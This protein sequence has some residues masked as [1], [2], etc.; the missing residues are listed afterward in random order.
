MLPACLLAAYECSE[1]LEVTRYVKTYRVMHRASGTARLCQ[2]LDYRS[3]VGNLREPRFDDIHLWA[4]L[5]HPSLCHIHEVLHENHRHL[6]HVVFDWPSGRLMRDI[7]FQN[8]RRRVRVPDPQLWQVLARLVD[9]L[10]YLHRPVR[11]RVAERRRFI[12]RHVTPDSIYIDDQGLPYLA[13]PPLPFLLGLKMISDRPVEACLYCAPEILMMRRY[14]DCVDMWS[15]GCTLYEY[16]TNTPFVTVVQP[17]RI[18][19]SCKQLMTHRAHPNVTPVYLQMLSRLLQFDEG[20]R[21][22]AARMRQ[23][24]RVKDAL[25]DEDTVTYHGRERDIS[26]LASA[27]ESRT[28]TP[29]LSDISIPILSATN[30]Q[31]EQNSDI[32]SCGDT[33]LTVSKLGMHSESLP[34]A[35]KPNGLPPR[36]RQKLEEENFGLTEPSITPEL[37]NIVDRLI[38]DYL[39]NEVPESVTIDEMVSQL[40]RVVP[41]F[42]SHGMKV[43]LHSPSDIALLHMLKAELDKR[44][45]QCKIQLCSSAFTSTTGFRVGTSRASFFEGSTLSQSNTLR[46]SSPPSSLLRSIPTELQETAELADT[47]GSERVGSP[48]KTAPRWKRSPSLATLLQESLSTGM[49]DMK[50]EL[51]IREAIYHGRF[52]LPDLQVGTRLMRSAARNDNTAV[53]ELLKAEGRLIDP[54]GRT[55]LMYATIAGNTTAIDLLR[56]IEAGFAMNNGITALMLAAYYNDVNTVQLLKHSEAQLQTIE[57]YTALMFATVRGHKE[58]VNALIGLEAGIRTNEGTTALMLAAQLGQTEIAAL[59]SPLESGLYN[60]H[61]E[62]ALMHA[63]V[64]LHETIAEELCLH[65]AGYLTFSGNTGLMF[66]ARMNLH[67]V[68]KKLVTRE[69]QLRN[70]KGETAL[71]F[72]A[73]MGNESLVELLAPVEAGARTENGQ[74]ALMYAASYGHIGV[75]QILSGQEK[76]LVD[77]VGTTA[78]MCAVQNSR[79][80]VAKYLSQVEAGMQRQGGETALMDAVRHSNIELVLLLARQERTLTLENG[81]TALDLAQS[82]GSEE[83]MRILMFMP[84]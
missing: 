3:L 84:N 1:P 63:I 39:N 16:A 59:L 14:T 38:I 28:I 68:A 17:E 82:I 78:L 62:T 56:P 54:D 76:R 33:E 72:A 22:S 7:I 25:N 18:R 10:A 57:G 20:A 51:R 13:P 34:P 55:A 83:L 81:Q 45:E 32:P 40:E 58:A 5:T 67:S 36:T 30:S 27:V 49:L 52:E 4:Q 47:Q 37:A 64:A 74:T 48:P 69:G 43:H 8:A 75:V 41:G 73:M 35:E 23:H 66:A 70:R 44:L 50:F 79:V 60:I 15:L 21:V 24:F 19:N 42:F 46:V 12:H 61:G 11:P 71:M 29:A 53:R 77:N 31:E 80:E 6:V 26:Y 65:E 2:S 9:A